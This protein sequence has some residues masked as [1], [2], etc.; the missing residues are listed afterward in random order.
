MP[1]AKLAVMCLIL[2]MALV[3]V[4]SLLGCGGPDDKEDS[5]AAETVSPEMVASGAGA[6]VH[7]P[8]TTA[9]A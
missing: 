4:A 5:A 6:I 2:V 8:T 3:F 9:Q 7:G 1:A